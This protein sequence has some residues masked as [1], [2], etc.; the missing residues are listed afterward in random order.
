MRVN[1]DQRGAVAVIV[2]IC[3]VMIFGFAAYAI[4]GG[5]L[6]E[7]RRGLVTAVDGAFNKVLTDGF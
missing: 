1:R 6:W 7:A 2:A 3:A 5:H 4:D